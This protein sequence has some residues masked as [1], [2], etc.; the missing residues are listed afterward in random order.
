MTLPF[1]IGG[2]RRPA[3]WIIRFLHPDCTPE[4]LF[5]R[6]LI[7]ELEAEMKKLSDER[8]LEKKLEQM[9]GGRVFR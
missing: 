8:R 3:P 5:V 2:I 7:K 6:R 1:I 9:L 4:K